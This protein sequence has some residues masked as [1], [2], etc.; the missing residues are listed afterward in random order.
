M[1]KRKF[2]IVLIK[3]SHYDDDGYVIQWRRSTIPSNSLASLYGL[4][5]RMRRGAR[6]RARRRHR[7]R[8]LSTNAT[9]S[10]TSRAISG[11]FAPRAAASSALSAFSRTSFRARSI[12]AGNSARAACRSSI[13]GFHVSGCL[14]MLPEMP[15][16]LKEA[17]GARHHPVRRR[18]RGPH[19]RAA[20]RRRRRRAEADLQL[21]QRL[22]DMDAAAIAGAAARGRDAGR[23]PLHE[24]RRRPRLPVPV[25]LLHHHQR[26]GAQV[27][28]SAPPTTSRR[29]CAPTPR[30]ASRASSSPTTISPATAIGS[31]SST[32]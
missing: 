6:A 27:A 9:R 13:G 4:L 2:P 19:G 25:Q 28:L 5:A 8:S 16:D 26:P 14:S 21:S 3:P 20:A 11:A 22:P 24:L 29:S 30:R 18:G 15:P 10:S 32:G 12:S 31:R 1:S 7:D 17:L 23:R